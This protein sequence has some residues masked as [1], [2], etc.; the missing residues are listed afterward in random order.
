MRTQY[1]AQRG[2]KQQI[3]FSLIELMISIAIGLVMVVFVTSLYVRSKNSYEVHDDNS[4]LQQDARIVM[5]L[6]GRNIS[7]AGFGRPTG[8]LKGI[9]E[10]GTALN[11]DDIPFAQALRA[12]DNGFSTPSDTAATGCAGGTGEPAFEVSYVTDT[13]VNTNTGAGTDCNG[14]TAPL[15]PAGDRVVVNRFYLATQNGESQSLFCV[16]N[17]NK[18]G[19]PLLGNV[20]KMRLTYGLAVKQAGEPDS[21]LDSAAKVAAAEATISPG[22]TPFKRVVS[23]NVCL[24]LSSAN[25][26]LTKAQQFRDC[27][28]VLV[29]ATD[30]RIHTTLNSTFTL[31]NNSDTTVLSYRK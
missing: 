22:L 28:G 1:P 24:Q 31:R 10:V 4:R 29:T 16:G 18:V 19:Q 5:A 7:Q 9:N 6:I 13:T 23:V 2:F 30:R 17:G 20:E 11:Q 15:S 26:V 3:G 21:F 25:N 8:S 14:Q 12:C 27:S